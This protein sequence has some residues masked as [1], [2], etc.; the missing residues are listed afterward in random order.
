LLIGNLLLL[1]DNVGTFLDGDSAVASHTGSVFLLV[2]VA[3]VQP[4]G[5]AVCLQARFIDVF[6][7][8]KSER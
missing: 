4:L 5:G 7:I 6:G 1:T 2:L 3:T 8:K